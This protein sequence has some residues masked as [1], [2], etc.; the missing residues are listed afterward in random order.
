MSE[1]AQEERVNY[2]VENPRT[3]ETL[4][5]VVEPSFAE[6][7]AFYAKAEAAFEKLR[8]M[9]VRQRL[10]E[11]GKFKRYLIANKEKVARRITEE[12][13]KSLMDSLC[14]DIYPICD[15]IAFY[16]KNA[17]KMLADKKVKTPIML[18]G[19]KSKV[20]YEPM[21][22]V[23]IIS[24]WNYPFHL[25]IAPFVC[26]FVAGNPVLLK[27]SKFTPLKG[28]VE[29]II[30]GSGF[31]E[32]GLQVVYASRRTANRLIE[33]RPAKIHFTGS[34]GVGRKIM[35]QAAEHLIP[36]ELELGGKDPAVIFDDV[37]IHRT[38]NGV[39]WGAFCNCGQTCTSIERLFVQDGIYDEFVRVLKEKTEKIVTL[40]DPKA[41]QD[42]LELTMGC[43]TAEFQIQEIEEQLAEAKAKGAD[44]LSGGSRAAGSHILP[45][46]LVAGAD[47]SMAVHRE[48]TFGPVL[49]VTRFEDED[50]AVRM[51]ND[52]VYGLM[53]SVWSADMERAERVARRLVVGAVSI[54]NVMATH[55]NPGLPFGGVKDSGFGRYR[56]VEG[57][58]AFSNVKAM[59]IDKQSGN[60]EPYWFPYSK[61]KF[62]LIAKVIDIAF[63][64]GL[65]SI[66]R[67]GLL[68]LKL[69]ALNRRKRL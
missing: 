25:S 41:Q 30:A 4:Y 53:A 44:I 32:G 55:G 21:G 12:T 66:A 50:E 14:L 63:S 54:N 58:H 6:V 20:V 15:I 65:L 40:S 33:K 18:I 59:L 49:T 35:A 62:G 34:V 45:P 61:E 38:V 60:V 16:E 1:I 68:K 19:K 69:D 17:E 57:L 8:S 64:G 47:N 67:T 56:G 9:T 22:P 11:L 24:P 37:N 3:N 27:P 52:S 7:D 26:A 36:V 29:D 31:M 42:E 48:E 39:L 43:M 51:A 13:G 2:T 10:D 46:T 28:V 5:E 23:L